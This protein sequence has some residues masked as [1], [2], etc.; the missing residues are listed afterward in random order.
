MRLHQFQYDIQAVTDDLKPS[1]FWGWTL[2]A[3][4]VASWGVVWV[5]FAALAYLFHHLPF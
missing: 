1:R 5:A 3:L 4:V 2:L